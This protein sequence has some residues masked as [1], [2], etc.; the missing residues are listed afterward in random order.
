M[1]AQE[2]AELVDLFTAYTANPDSIGRHLTEAASARTQDDPL[3]VATGTDLALYPGG[4]REPQVEGF[5]MS[6]RGFK[7]LAGVSHLG[8]ALA[9]LV[10]LRALGGD[11]TWRADGQRLLGQ[12][13]VARAANSEGLWRDTIA[14]AAYRGRERQIAAMIDYTCAVTAR[15]LR[16][17][18]ADESYL[19][20]ETLRADYLT[21][22]VGAGGGPGVPM[23]HMMIATFFLAGMDIAHRVIAWFDGQGIDWS[24]AMVLIAGKQGR[25]TSGVTWRTSSVAAMVLGASRQRL[26]LERLYM[27]PHAPVFGTP[28]N[29]DLSEV[30]ALEPALRGL[31]NGVWATVE[32]GAVMFDGYPGFTPGGADQPDLDTG[33]TEVAEMPLIHSAD[34][35]LA[36]VTRLRVVLEDPRQLLSGCVVDF[37]VEQLAA[38]NN[39]PAAV[40]V[41]GLDGV[42]YPVGLFR[43]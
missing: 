14:V 4:G 21:R 40:T 1:P 42:D 18:L 29:G 16:T 26:P 7:E 39:D 24:R 8:P 12:V 36:M 35:M 20:A 33:L 37:A 23:N 31:W 11:S 30:K 6:T 9:S 17:A 5:R 28:V 41:P 34:D 13:E 10:N 3:I 32:L 19:T 15:Y 25:P 22:G 2:S 27:A 38:N 43:T